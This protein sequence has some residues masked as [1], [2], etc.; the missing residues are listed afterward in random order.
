MSVTIPTVIV[1]AYHG[2]AWMPKCVATLR[3]SLR[4]PVRLVLVDNAG[5]SC[6]DSLEL[7]GLD[8][9]VLCC[10]RPLGFAEANNFALQHID[11]NT[12]AVCFLNQ[13][14]L[15]EPGWLEAC[16]ECLRARPGLGAVTPMIAT[17]DGQGWDQAFL[18]CA[19]WSK[20]FCQDF[21]SNGE[22]PS[23]PTPLPARARGDVAD[24]YEVPEITAAAMVV[25]TE[26]LL[27]A[28]PFDPIYGSYYE[29][30]DLCRRIREAGCGIGVCT[31]GKIAHFGGSATAN[32]ETRWQRVRQI[33][34]NRVI[35]AV[36]SAGTKRLR[37]LLHYLNWKFPY[38]LGRSVWGT[39][40]ST[41]LRAYLGAH[42][43]LVRVL[44]RLVSRR[45]D[46]KAWGD[47]L[48]GLGWPG[49]R[50]AVS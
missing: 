2:D 41:P 1:V 22:L 32:D 37:T 29:D 11:F 23:P 4:S 35:Y 9:V 28:G 16:T 48:T 30:Y 15:S 25:R 50:Q 26:A 8:H 42:L 43:D 31:R 3:A 36:R 6:L 5:N 45:R 10:D 7:D 14:T 39:S 24:F 33:T 12:E 49:N 44:P 17:Y 27:E 38:N 19:R 13:D 34:R 21:D 20:R 47:Y 40:S 46:E 18:E